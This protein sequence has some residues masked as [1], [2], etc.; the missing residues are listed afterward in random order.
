MY[1][2]FVTL[3]PKGYRLMWE[4]HEVHLLL[5]HMNEVDFPFLSPP[6]VPTTVAS[7]EIQFMCVFFLHSKKQEILG[8]TSC[9]QSDFKGSQSCACGHTPADRFPV[10]HVICLL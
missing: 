4:W 8:G 7:K 9:G 6:Q 3:V 1:K 10:V 5:T 2:G